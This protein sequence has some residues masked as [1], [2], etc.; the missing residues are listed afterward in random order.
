MPR[1]VLPRRSRALAVAVGATIAVAALAACD[2]A[3]GDGTTAAPSATATAT[4]TAEVTAAAEPATVTWDHPAVEGY[5]LSEDPPTDTVEQLVNEELACYLQFTHE[6]I[7]DAGIDDST[8]TDTAITNAT[9]ALDQ[10][11]ETAREDSA[12]PSDAGPLAARE[13][14]LD[15]RSGS[16]ELEV[17]MLLRASSADQVLVGVVQICPAGTLDE[18]AWDAVVAGTTLH[19]TTATEF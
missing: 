14:T 11:T 7:P 1:P 15:A 17:K 6:V 8:Y 19:G 4:A 16:Q 12:I 3:S 10:A 2:G 5:V 9:S 13:V 18:A